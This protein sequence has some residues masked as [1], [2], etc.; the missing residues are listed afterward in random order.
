MSMYSYEAW[1]WVISI[2]SLVIA[3]CSLAMSLI[4]EVRRVRH[5]RSSLPVTPD[6]SVVYVSPWAEEEQ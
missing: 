4:A 2:C 5:A 1:T 6:P 3:V